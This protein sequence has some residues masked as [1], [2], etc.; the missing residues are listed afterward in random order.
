MNSVKG[1]FK[2]IVIL[3]LPLTVILMG[4]VTAVHEPVYSDGVWVLDDKIYGFPFPFIYN[5]V[6]SSLD[7]TFILSHFLLD[8]ACY[9]LIVSLFVQSVLLVLKREVGP[10]KKQIPVIII[11]SLALLV[12]QANIYFAIHWI[13]DF[14]WGFNAYGDELVLKSFQL[15][16]FPWSLFF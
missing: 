3:M 7:Q 4:T 15:V 14:R 6:T 2:R 10:R 9:F 11:N 16:A 12:I 8:F 5:N 1:F 13:N